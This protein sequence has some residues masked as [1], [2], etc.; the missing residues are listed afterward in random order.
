MLRRVQPDDEIL[1]GLITGVTVGIDDQESP[2]RFASASR[3]KQHGVMLSKLRCT[4]CRRV[5]GL[6]SPL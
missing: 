4:D 5:I 2:A 3:R 1:A 6:T